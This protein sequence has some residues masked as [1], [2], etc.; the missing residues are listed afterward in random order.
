MQG[1]YLFADAAV[2]SEIRWQGRELVAVA[3]DT[4]EQ[5]EDAIAAIEVEYEVLE[6]WVDEADVEGAR[7]AGRANENEAQTAGDVD[8]G[9]AQ[10]DKIIEGHYGIPTITHCCWE[11][12]GST[13]VWDGRSLTAYLSTQNLSLIHI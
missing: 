13:C 3:A 5:A 1:V 6:H 10:A 8:A 4:P 2:G 12:H 11:T 7:A 9:F